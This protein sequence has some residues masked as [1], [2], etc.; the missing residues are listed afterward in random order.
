ML[1]H[2]L[3]TW[4]KS[5]FAVVDIVHCSTATEWLWPGVGMERC[6]LGRVC[7]VSHAGDGEGGRRTRG[8]S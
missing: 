8:R 5:D 6:G 2:Y 4:R 7:E 1:C 3:T